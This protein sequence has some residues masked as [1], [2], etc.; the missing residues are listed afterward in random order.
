MSQAPRSM[1]SE[2]N[3]RRARRVRVSNLA[4][5]ECRK[6]VLGVGPNLVATTLDL[7]ETGAHFVLKAVL[8][9]G[10]DVEILMQGGGLARPLKRLARVVWSVPLEKGQCCAGLQFQQPLPFADL[11]RFSRS[12]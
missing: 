4:K 3:R 8:D 2:A 10:Q 5:V 11:A 7:S 12:M 1:A 6:G 9:K